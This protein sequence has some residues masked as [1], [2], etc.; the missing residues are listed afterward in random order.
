M[1]NLAIEDLFAGLGRVTIKRLFG[2]KAVY[3]DGLVVGIVR[4]DGELLLKV[5]VET[6]PRFEAAGATQ[7]VHTDKSGKT[8]SMP[9]WTVPVDAFDDPESM[10]AW[11][12]LAAAAA[13]RAD[14]RKRGNTRLRR[15]A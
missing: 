9:Y 5:D 7:W 13:R 10:A 1:D 8:A 11:V 12:K 4:R 2:G 15:R 3:F 6:A 14:I